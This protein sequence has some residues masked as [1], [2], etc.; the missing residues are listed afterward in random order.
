MRCSKKLAKLALT[1]IFVLS[2][3]LIPVVGQVSP[4][5]AVTWTK[6][7]GEVTLDNEQYVVDAWVIKDG[8]TYKMWY[9]H[10]TSDESALTIVQTI[11]S[12]IPSSLIGK[13]AS[14]ALVGFLTDLSTI[15]SGDIT[16]IKGMLDGSSTVIGYA[17][18]TNGTTW[19]RQDTEVLAG[20]GKAW[21]SVGAPC[22]IKV[23][24][25]D[26][27]MWY[28]RTK[29]D[30]TQPELETILDGMATAGQRKDALLDL[31]DGTSTVIGYATW[32]GVADNWTVVN[33]E[34]LAGGS[35]AWLSVADPSV[36][37]DG[38]TYRMWYTR[39]ETDLST[40]GIQSLLNE[41]AGLINSFWTIL[42]DFTSGNITQLV[43]DLSALD[44]TTM[45]S[46]LNDS[47]TV[48]G[49]ATSTSGTSWTV[50][51]SQHLVGVSGSAW[52]SVA[53]PSVIKDGTTYRLW[54]TDGIAT[55]TVQSLLDLVIGTDLPI[56]YASY[57]IPAGGDGDAPA[58]AVPPA[59]TAETVEEMTIEEAVETIE[60]ATTEEAAA[61]IE[62]VT[63]ETAAAIIEEVSTET[64]AAIIEEVATETAAD[65]IEEVAT[66]TA[67]DIIE[68]V[69]TEKAA[70]IIEEV[71]TEKAADIIEEV[72]IDKAAAIMQEVSTPKLE[73]IIPQMTEDSLKERLPEL[74]VDKLETISLS[75][76]LES[77]PTVL[78]VTLSPEDPPELPP[79]LPE[80]IVLVTTPTGAQ[81]LAIRTTDLSSSSNC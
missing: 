2:S 71:A 78:A 79:D 35:S 59:P 6:Y 53:A 7:T 64:A 29:T 9:T 57:T 44:M 49:Y 26:Y 12:A 67:A 81:Y 48:I 37:K 32:D 42:D 17:T 14:L 80:P 50:V 54:Y 25:T 41:T 33:S 63:T 22:V 69:V 62:E 5:Q 74:T 61:I 19:T 65:I 11:T 43:N 4:V 39:G 23:S 77:L 75:V 46:L 47:S 76:L 56:G 34:V 58:E 21:K 18:S 40:Y 20:D 66:E 10:A 1:V 70:D 3:V 8:T 52:S 45:R 38:S 55:L 68:E 73:Q 31:L 28:T 13:I 24:D 60:E 30:L 16:Q 27:R 15:P 51:N 72:A 36:I